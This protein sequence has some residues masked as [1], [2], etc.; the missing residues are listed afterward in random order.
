MPK[1]SSKIVLCA[2]FL[3]AFISAAFIGSSE[4]LAET[5]YECTQKLKPLYPTISLPTPP[6]NTQGTNYGSSAWYYYYPYSYSG[7]NGWEKAFSGDIDYLQQGGCRLIY[8]YQDWYN[9]VYYMVLLKF[10][11]DPPPCVWSCQAYEVTY[12][13]ETYSIDKAAVGAPLETGS[14]DQPNPYPDPDYSTSIYD[15]CPLP[16]GYPQGAPNQPGTPCP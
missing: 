15:K 2:L 7:H 8:A 10:D 9:G 5:V 14:C 4:S 11:C 3:F 12:D 1:P 6:F 13:C 16:G